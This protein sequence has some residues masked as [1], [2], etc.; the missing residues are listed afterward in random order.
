[1]FIIGIKQFFSGFKNLFVRE[2][3]AVSVKLVTERGNGFYAWGGKLYQSDIVRACIR[4]KIK[5]VGK[6]VGKHIRET[7]TE[8]GKGITVNPDAYLRFLLEEPNPIMTG[9]LL[10]E[11]LA[12]QLCLNNN[13]FALITR[14]E[15]GI[16]VQI[17]PLPAQNVEARYS[18]SGELYLRFLFPNGKQ[19]DFPYCDIIHLRQDFHDNDIFGESPAKAITQLMEIVN[20]ID[21]G[22]VNAIKNSAVVQ[23]LLKF[24]SSIRTEDIEKNARVFAE[25]FL[26]TKNNGLG[27]AAIDAKADAIRVE[28]KEYVPNATQMDK[29]TQRIYSFFNT[30]TKIVQSAFT[31][32]EW[33]SYYEAE[34]E[35][36]VVQ[37]GGEYTRK[38]FTRRARGFGNY[39]VFEAANLQC[40]SISTKLNLLQMVDRGAMTPN[41]WRATFNLAPLP[42][43][44]KAIRRLDTAPVDKAKEKEETAE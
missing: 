37:L 22:I 17:Y 21:Q 26:S 2:K 36:I 35:P 12:T 32:D 19:F 27:V 44:D 33:N 9:Q 13:A 4:P 40:A 7:I 1:M 15:N 8:S 25:T 18:Q 39:I 3:S 42:D 6:L 28:P 23:W 43:G 16:P 11:K 30:N 34:I 14:D 38:I 29:T 20:T 41:E 31:E 5:A 24:N 10:Q